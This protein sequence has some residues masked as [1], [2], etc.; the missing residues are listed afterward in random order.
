[1][2][3]P[4]S[5]ASALSAPGERAGSLRWVVALLL[6]PWMD[7]SP[8]HRFHDSD[9]LVPVLMSLQRW[10][11]FYWEQNRFGSLLPLLAV[12]STGRFTTCWSRWACVS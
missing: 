10:T 2:I 1:M 6:A 9:S 4:P 11:P 8:L 3:S 12:P 5:S 7:L